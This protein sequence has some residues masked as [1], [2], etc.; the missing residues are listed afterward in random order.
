MRTFFSGNRQWS[1]TLPARLMGEGLSSSEDDSA[2][3]GGA[4]SRLRSRTHSR[5]LPH[6]LLAF[7]YAWLLLW[8]RLLSDGSANA[9]AVLPAL[10]VGFCFYGI[11]LARLATV[12]PFGHSFHQTAGNLWLLFVGYSIW[13]GFFPPA[14]NKS[15][16]EWGAWL[17]VIIGL[18]ATIAA[19]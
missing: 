3:L 2:T 14:G 8:D 4:W 12:G 10:A 16:V 5:V 7:L 15:W 6:L 1:M 11:V 9:A 13:L 17:L 18:A 19:A